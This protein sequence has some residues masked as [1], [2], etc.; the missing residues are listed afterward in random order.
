MADVFGVPVVAMIE[1]EGAALGGALQA[2][3]CVALRGGRKKAKLAD[4][5]QGTV[6]INEATR[7]APNQA[8]V[9]RYRE[10]QAVQDRLSLA[11]RGV[12]A[13]QRKLA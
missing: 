4:F 8:N 7:C 3:W 5:T 11:L 2:A 12:F 10:L 6:A 1:D 9:A 13:D